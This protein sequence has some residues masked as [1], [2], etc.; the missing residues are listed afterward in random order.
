MF[1]IST[2]EFVKT[3]CFFQNKKF[4]ISG[5]DMPYLDILDGKLVSFAPSNLSKCN[6]SCKIKNLKFGIIYTLG[7][8]YLMECIYLLK[9]VD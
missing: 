9:Y 8:T 4:L 5:P 1:E 2:L 3:Q 7:Q 6:I